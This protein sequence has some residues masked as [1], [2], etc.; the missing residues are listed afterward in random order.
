[1][2]AGTYVI[3]ADCLPN[4]LLIIINSSGYLPYSDRP[5]PG[6]Q[7]PHLP[8]TQEL[9]FFFGFSVLLLTGTAIVAALFVVAGVILAFCRLPGWALRLVAA[10]IAF[11]SAGLMMDGAGWYIAISALGVYI[12]A[13]C[14]LL[15]G[16][17]VFP[18][19]VP[20]MSRTSPRPARIALK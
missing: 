19:L 17:F 6:W 1:W 10:P 9:G 13:G 20:Q 15:W 12:A 4:L 14:G 11:L 2:I 5:G 18:W 7:M 16:I 3:A 8:T